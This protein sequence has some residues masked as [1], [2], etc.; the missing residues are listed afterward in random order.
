MTAGQH[1]VPNELVLSVPTAELYA[2]VGEWRGV[3]RDSPEIWRFLARKSVFRPRPELEENPAMK[4]LISY[5]LFV[6]DRRVFVM[7]RLG[8]QGESRLHGLLSIGV[9]GHMNPAKEIT[10]PGRRRIADL[11]ALV[12]I[13]TQR[14]IKEEVCFP[15]KPPISVL[16]FLND[17]KN[18]VGRV[19]LGLVTVVHLPA[20]ILAVRE[21]DKMLG[22][23]VEISK[24]GLL[25]KFESWSSLVL[26]GIS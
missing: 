10:W 2:A 19:H 7:K 6:S 21:T 11:K 18:A 4:Q 23:W 8:T 5:T 20:P 24:L 16:G 9:G 12:T 1:T 14:E 3:R 26:E 22:A 25:G 17:D 15:G 13:N